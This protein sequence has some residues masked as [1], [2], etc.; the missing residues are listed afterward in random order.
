MSYTLQ[1]PLAYFPLPT[2]SSAA[3]LC[4]LYVG[5]IDAD[6]LTPANQVQVYAVQPDGSELAIPQP[7]QLSA[8]GVPQYNG[9]P[10][11]LTFAVATVSIKVTTSIGALVSYTPRWSAQVSADALAAVDST[12]SIGGVPAK[13]VAQLIRGGSF[14]ADDYGL[15][16]T[17]NGL[18]NC[19]ALQALSA[20]V[21]AAGGGKVSF[22]RGTF[23]VGAQ[24]LAGATGKGY[25]YLFEKMF[26]V[27]DLPNSGIHLDFEGTKFEFEDG[28]RFGAFNPVTGQPVVTTLPEWN[29]DLAASTG[30]VFVT[31][32]VRDVLVTGKCEIDGRDTTRIIGGQFGD[33][34]TQCSE[35]GFQFVNHRRLKMEGLI[36]CHNLLLDGLYTLGITG[37]DECYTSIDGY[38]GLYNARQ[39]W[40]CCGGSNNFAVNSVFGLTGYGRLTSSPAS[41]LDLEPEGTAIKGVTVTNCWF[42]RSKGPCYVSD[43][44]NVN[45]VK[46]I[47][48]EFENTEFSTVYSV[49]KDI[50]FDTCT[51]RG[52]VFNVIA[53]T[54]PNQGGTRPKFSNCDFYD[55]TRDGAFAKRYAGTGGNGGILFNT[56]Q[57]D[58]DNCR[59]YAEISTTYSVVGFMDGSNLRNFTLFV[60]GVWTNMTGYEVFYCRNSDYIENFLINNTG[61]GEQ[62]GDSVSSVTLTGTK[63]IVNAY[64]TPNAS[65]AANTLVWDFPTISSGARALARRNE[66]NQNP[67]AWVSLGLWRSNSGVT[68]VARDGAHK[69]FSYSA[70]PT[71]GS[72]ARG[73]LI[74]NN[75]TSASGVP[76]WSCT[77]AGVAGS[78]AVFKPFSNLGA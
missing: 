24:T 52:I 54:N 4:K 53:G 61:T 29:Y 37:G 69:I 67:Q 36:Y 48:C 14:R 72:F 38:I 6:P 32:N 65:G 73:D 31:V 2:K 18:Q 60:S 75:T 27:R 55:R 57:A 51:F 28:L 19:L 26:D 46:F 3:G 21:K 71:S 66:D 23:R 68:S 50:V 44:F 15:K 70:I 63:R 62:A 47:G 33:S 13:Q 25:S 77:V 9:S 49:L 64:I 11:Q 39:A 59:G 43:N 76:A 10:V 41:G 56:V 5:L 12:V 22:P 42:P 1:N 58:F 34:G 74:L 17:N 16:T 45:G 30:Y 78:T 7:I 40:S 35:Y 8:G 20:A